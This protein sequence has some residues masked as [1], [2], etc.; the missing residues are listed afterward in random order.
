MNQREQTTS[1]EHERVYHAASRCQ[2]AS[3]SLTAT[4]LRGLKKACSVE[5][6]K[7][8]GIFAVQRTRLAPL[9]DLGGLGSIPGMR[10][11]C[12]LEDGRL[13]TLALEPH[14]EDDPQPDIGECSHG[15]GMAFARSSLALVVV[16]GPSFLSGAL[17]SKLM[18][19]VAQGLDAAVAPVGLE[20][21]PALEEH[22]RGSSQGLQ[23]RRIGIATAIIA[24][25]G[26]QT[27]CE[28]LPCS[29]QRGEDLAIRMGQKKG[30]DLLVIG[31]NLLHQ[32]QELRNQCQHQARFGTR[33]D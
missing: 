11:S 12:R 30:V 25:F 17:P 33:G 19:R 9:K 32:G 14:G 6:E 10:V 1:I 2:A 13:V 18:Q 31:A 5:S 24:D 27:R 26:E 22:R 20:V 21:H 15:D 29:R 8:A 3:L 16:P 4:C 23:T 7:T 28:S